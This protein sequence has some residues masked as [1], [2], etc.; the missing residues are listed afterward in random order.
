MSVTIANEIFY[1]IKEV[2]AK[3]KVH[4]Q[5]VHRWINSGNLNVRKISPKKFYIS[6]NDLLEFMKGKIK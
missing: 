5:T 1:K 4:I 6:E 2:A 3:Y